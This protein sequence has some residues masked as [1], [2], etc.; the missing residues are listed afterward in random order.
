MFIF[1]KIFI[2]LTYLKQSKMQ[3]LL[4]LFYE[5][6]KFVLIGGILLLFAHWLFSPL[7]VS[8]RS[9]EK[10]NG[11]PAA[12]R[13]ALRLQAY[14]RLVLLVERIRPSALLV[15]LHDPLL[16]AT[17]FQDLL[18]K[19]VRN[20]FEHNISQQLY[21][22][23]GAWKMMKQLREDTIT[24]ICNASKQLP[25]GATSLDYAKT[26][27]EYLSTLEVSPYDAALGFLKSDSKKDKE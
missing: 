2:F 25:E 26:M 21:V 19:E 11:V 9:S 22:S 24:L 12:D 20:E 16:K 23:D 4:T 13:Q 10:G 1:V 27:L 17:E 3:E 5:I 6:L 7:F 8:S 14:E 18:L 15:R